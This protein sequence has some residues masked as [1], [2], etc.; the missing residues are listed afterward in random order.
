MVLEGI[1]RRIRERR[2][3]IAEERAIS[4]I[5]AQKAAA[6]ARQERVKLAPKIAVEK[7]RI[8]AQQEIKRFRQS[9]GQKKSAFAGFDKFLAGTGVARGTA[10]IIRKDIFDPMMG[11][12]TKRKGGFKVI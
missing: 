7:E 6:A 9:G 12:G 4:K 2:L 3:R 5:A 10:P 11:N 8:R 1:K